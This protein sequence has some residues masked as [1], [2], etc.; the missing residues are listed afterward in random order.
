MEG[1]AND[2]WMHR[3]IGD[4]VFCGKFLPRGCQQERVNKKNNERGKDTISP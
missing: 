3:H 1:P 2:A 4:L